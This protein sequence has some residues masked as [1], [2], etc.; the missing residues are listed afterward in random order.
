MDD[1]IG[2]VRGLSIVHSMLSASKWAPLPLSDLATKVIYASLKALPRGKRVSVDVTPSPVRV[3]SDQ[4]HNL[5]LV[6]NELATNTVKYALR[7]CDSAQITFQISLD[8]DPIQAVP[9]VRCEFR[10]DGPGYPEDALRL[11][12]HNVGFDLIQNIVRGSLHGELSLYN[13]RGAV[14]VIRF[15]AQV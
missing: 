3:T 5:A 12:R 2:R 6:I 8:D 15:K 14:V 4:A 9:M 13:D 10:D 7:E 11:E 1:L